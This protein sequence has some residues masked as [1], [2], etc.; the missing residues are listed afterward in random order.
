MRELIDQKRW[1]EG[2][3]VR[4]TPEDRMDTARRV[5]N[6]RNWD[7]QARRGM[8][9]SMVVLYPELAKAVSDEVPEETA[10]RRKRYT[11]WRS[12]RDRQE[13]HKKLIEEIIPA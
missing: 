10:T 6:A 4:M 3:L 11:S 13:Q 5:H 12:Y 1:L 9:A 7:A 8:L 2:V